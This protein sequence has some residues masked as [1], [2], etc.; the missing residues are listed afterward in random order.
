MPA[1]D[2]VEVYQHFGWS[3]QLGVRPQPMVIPLRNVKERF[4]YVTDGRLRGRI[5]SAQHDRTGGRGMSVA[6]DGMRDR[7]R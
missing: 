3:N 7:D 4:L 1:S 5:T 6:V 2:G